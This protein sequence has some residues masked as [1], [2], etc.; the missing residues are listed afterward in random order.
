[1]SVIQ[2]I[3][4]TFAMSDETREGL[5]LLVVFALIG[6]AIFAYYF[7]AVFVL[8]IAMSR[9][10]R[11]DRRVDRSTR[12]LL[13]GCAAFP[14][15]GLGVA[16]LSR[17]HSGN[18]EFYPSWI[19]LCVGS[20]IVAMPTIVLGFIFPNRRIPLLVVGTLVWIVVCAV[21]GMLDP[22]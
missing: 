15:I 13:V 21:Y 20:V 8:P 4:A 19:W 5:Q 18:V 12:Q 7:A 22:R 6:L 11:P 17:E 3:P 9:L 10:I 16:A 2:S 1:M 14:P